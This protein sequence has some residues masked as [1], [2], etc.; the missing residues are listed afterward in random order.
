MQVAEGSPQTEDRSGKVSNTHL[1]PII[2]SVLSRGF[3][4]FY[5]YC[6]SFFIVLFSLIYG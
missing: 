4:L 3:F 5:S 1:V 6:F 2:P